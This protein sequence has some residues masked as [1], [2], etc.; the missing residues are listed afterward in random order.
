MRPTLKDP[1]EFALVKKVY[2]KDRQILNNDL[3]PIERND[4]IES[5]LRNKHKSSR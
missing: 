1:K 3:D 2:F 5:K 4:R